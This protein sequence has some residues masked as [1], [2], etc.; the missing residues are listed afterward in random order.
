MTTDGT[1][2]LIFDEKKSALDR[3]L[4]S[5]SSSVNQWSN[6]QLPVHRI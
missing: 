5:I 4:F 6:Q 2:S 3:H 1:D